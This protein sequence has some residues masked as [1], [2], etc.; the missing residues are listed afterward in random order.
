MSELSKED[1]V[2]A[3]KKILGS[4]HD[5]KSGL[6]INFGKHKGMHISDVPG[7]Y[8]RWMIKSEKFSDYFVEKLKEEIRRRSKRGKFKGDDLDE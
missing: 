5:A 2:S 7:G 1:Q 8:I 3:I 4:S 6:V